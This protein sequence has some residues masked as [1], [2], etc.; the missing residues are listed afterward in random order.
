MAETD[1]AL[2][3]APRAPHRWSSRVKAGLVHLGL[4]A[5]VAAAVAALVLALWYPFPYRD[6]S[7]G[8]E[9]FLLIIGVDV[10]VGPLLTLVVFDRRKPRT[11]RVRDVLTIV[12]LQAVA[13]LYGMYT[14][15]QARPAVIALEG[16]RLRVVR[17]IDLANADW[18]KAPPGLDAPSLLGPIFVAARAP[19]SAEK[20]DTIERG[21]AGEDIGMRPSFWVAPTQTGAAYAQA[22]KPIAKLLRLRPDGREAIEAALTGKR[23]T[24]DAVGY[25]PILARRTDWSAL[26]N[27]KDGAIIGYVPIDGF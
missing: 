8:R 27:L 16:D 10:I 19:T 13:L 25:L 4:S 15:Y 23:L 17:P 21:L 5:L 2:N 24:L 26:V 3:A 12:L 18:S 1:S 11:E 6:I 9:L 22:A 20:L 7:G 14:V